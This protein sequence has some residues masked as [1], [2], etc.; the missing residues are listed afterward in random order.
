MTCDI[1]T[2][3]PVQGECGQYACECGSTGYRAKSG[4]IVRHK[5][6]HTHKAAVTAQPLG[7]RGYAPNVDCNGGSHDT[8]RVP[9]RPGAV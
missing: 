3:R 6:R 8:W 9:R 5:Q 4:R 2:W 1:H 7:V